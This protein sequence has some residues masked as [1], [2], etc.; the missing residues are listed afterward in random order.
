MV[1][2][3]RTRSGHG[4]TLRLQN[5]TLR[6][7]ESSTQSEKVQHSRHFSE[8]S[9]CAVLQTHFKLV[10]ILLLKDKPGSITSV[11]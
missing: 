4:C 6:E 5:W 3:L 1:Y 9:Q 10:L 8:E 2:F 7:I 11:K